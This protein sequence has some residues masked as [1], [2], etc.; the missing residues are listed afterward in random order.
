MQP[1]GTKMATKVGLLPW[2]DVVY[3]M[4]VGSLD[5]WIPECCLS[6]NIYDPRMSRQLAAATASEY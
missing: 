2:H 6:G 4:D 3:S 1:T 5:E